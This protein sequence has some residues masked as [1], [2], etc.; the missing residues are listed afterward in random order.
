MEPLKFLRRAHDQAVEMA[1]PLKLD[2]LDAQRRAAL[3]LYGTIVELAGAFTALC[4]QKLWVGAP[5]VAR[6]TLEA[7]IDLRNTCQDAKYVRNLEAAVG[8]EQLRTYKAA[9]DEKNLYFEGVRAIGGLDE[10]MERTQN[11]VEELKMEG[12]GSLTIRERF[13][14]AQAEDIYLSVYHSLCDEAHNGLATLYSR[15]LNEKNEVRF[16]LYREEPRND[17]LPLVDLAASILNDATVLVHEVL[18]TGNAEAATKL[19]N[20]LAKIRKGYKLAG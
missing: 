18:K 1:K 6:C 11:R 19:Q 16:A 12:C 2:G 8:I 5:T 9:R 13:T 14:R 10:I 3:L 20:E 4:E 7:Y 15:Q 17:F